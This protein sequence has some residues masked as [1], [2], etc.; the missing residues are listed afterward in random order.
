MFKVYYGM[1]EEIF[2]FFIIDFCDING[3]YF[4]FEMFLLKLIKEKLLIELMDEEVK[5]VIQIRVFDSDMQI[6]VYEN[7]NKFISVI[8]IIRKVSFIFNIFNNIIY[9][10]NKCQNVSQL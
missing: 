2:G 7:Y 9:L 10:D 4:D 5:I 3:V 1:E 8:D 6:L